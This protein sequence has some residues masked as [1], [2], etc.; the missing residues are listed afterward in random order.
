M[1]RLAEQDFDVAVL[2]CTHYP[3]LEGH[4]KSCLPK[5]VQIISS[6]VETVRDVEK[7]LNDKGIRNEKFIEGNVLFYTTGPRENFKPI[8][9]DW[10]RLENPDVRTITLP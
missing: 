3:L 5:H 10:L 8:V 1:Q 9:T 6:A 7:E 2:G 4:I